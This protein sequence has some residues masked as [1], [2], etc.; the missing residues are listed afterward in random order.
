MYKHQFY[1]TRPCYIWQ[2]RYVIQD[3][4]HCSLCLSKTSLSK[5]LYSSCGIIIFYSE[6]V[7]RLHASSMLNFWLYKS[8]TQYTNTCIQGSYISKILTSSSS[9]PTWI[10]P[11]FPAMPSGCTPATN[12]LMVLRSLLPARLIPRLPWPRFKSTTWRSPFKSPYCRCIFSTNNIL[13]S[14]V[15]MMM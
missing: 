11:S 13:F 6:L 2:S 4:T 5:H 12:T 3:C 15:L 8:T 10:R 9:S 7:G 1:L 14:F